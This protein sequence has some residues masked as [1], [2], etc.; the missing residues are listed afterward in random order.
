MH[1]HWQEDIINFASSQTGENDAGDSLGLDG[2][3][4]RARH[5][6]ARREALLHEESH[7]PAAPAPAS[8]TGGVAA[9]VGAKLGALTGYRSGAGGGGGSQPESMSSAAEPQ[10]LE[11]EKILEQIRQNSMATEQL[12]AAEAREKQGSKDDDTDDALSGGGDTF[13]GVQVDLDKPATWGSFKNSY[14]GKVCD[15]P[16]S[17]LKFRNSESNSDVFLAA[18]REVEILK[19]LPKHPNI[20]AYIG[21]IQPPGKGVCIV[22]ELCKYGQLDI[23]LREHQAK[24]QLKHRMA[25]I[26]QICSGMQGVVSVGVIHRDLAAHNVLVY[27]LRPVQVKI[28][29]FGLAMHNNNQTAGKISQAPRPG[30]HMGKDKLENIHGVRWAALEILDAPHLEAAPWSE[31]TDVWAYGVT[32]WQVFAHG[33]VPYTLA[34]P[35]EA[36]RLFVIRGRRLGTPIGCPPDVYETMMVRTWTAAADRPTFDELSEAMVALQERH[37]K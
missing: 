19:M 12:R 11:Q 16:V 30:L 36:V 10:W 3:Q 13:G 31:K 4:L 32:A 18:C 1:T 23:F 9:W 25:M 26:S 5:Q 15:V 24:I 29:D 6:I 8:A 37:M 17:V 34:M 2:M 22:M 21:T 14:A 7:S 33:E 27:S 28:I 20:N 35:D